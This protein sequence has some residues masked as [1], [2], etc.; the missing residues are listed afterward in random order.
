MTQEFYIDQVSSSDE[1]KFF[2]VDR[3]K[4]EPYSSL[5]LRED[6]STCPGFIGKGAGLSVMC[7]YCFISRIHFLSDTTDNTARLLYVYAVSVPLSRLPEGEEIEQWYPLVPKE[8]YLSLRTALRIALCFTPSDKARLR[9]DSMAQLQRRVPGQTSQFLSSS[10]TSEISLLSPVGAPS[11]MRIQ[12]PPSPIQSPVSISLKTGVIDYVIIVGPTGDASDTSDTRLECQENSLLFRYPA[13]D[14]PQ[15]PLPTKIEWFCFPGGPEVIIQASRPPSKLFSFVLVGGDDG[16]SRTY[17]VCLTVYHRPKVCSSS[18]RREGDTWHAT[19]VA[20]LTRVPLVDELKECLLAVAHAWLASKTTMMT[21]T[22]DSEGQLQATKSSLAEE[23][24][25][26]LCHRVL[27]PIRGVFGVQ[28]SITSMPISLVLPTNVSIYN[29]GG[30]QNRLSLQ[31][32][33]RSSLVGKFSPTKSPSTNFINIQQGFQPLV[34]SLAPIFQLFDIKTVIHLVALIL[35]EFRVLIHSSQFSLLC[36]FA[37]G[38]CALIYPFRWQHPYVPILPRVLSEYLQAPLPYILGVHTSWLPELLENGRPEHLV[39]VDI[40]RGAIQLQESQGPMLPSRLTKGLYQRIKRIIH[41]DVFDQG[42]TKLVDGLVGST[43]YQHQQNDSAP[44]CST[45]HWNATI[46]KQVRVEFVCYLSAMLMGYR[47]CL[48]F[49]NQKLPVFNKRRYF[50]TCASDNEVV[51]FVTRLFCTQ[52]F[53]GFLENHSSSELSV[54]HSVYLTFSRSKDLEWPQSM[55]PMSISSHA[56]A[57]TKANGSLGR[58]SG[59]E[60]SSIVTPVFTMPQVT[61]V[62]ESE[63]E[64]VERNASETAAPNSQDAME[65]DDSA[66]AMGESEPSA[67]PS[68]GVHIEELLDV[69]SGELTDPF[70][71]SLAAL[72]AECAKSATRSCDYKQ[73]AQGMGVDPRILEENAELFRDPHQV[74]QNQG[75]HHM[76]ASGHSGAFGGPNTRSLSN[77]EERTEQVLHKCLTS[78]FASDDM[79]T[80][81]DVRVSECC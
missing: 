18:K 35:C 72:E 46:E 53:Q 78:V 79:I 20:F 36:P 49:V 17:A 45:I 14:R 51:P 75:L 37:E 39:I 21:M 43:Q 57:T 69:L 80:P 60:S 1:F 74:N 41:P 42:G 48:F 77:E 58:T 65:H 62:L 32:T 27:I 63:G 6:V 55:P 68:L 64:D 3:T 44:H 61:E 16:M 76:G 22:R 30:G 23:L 71:M 7:R 38:L 9:V 33:K 8:T 4:N 28:F 73:V 52:A 50:S 81:E 59:R 19:C 29:S 5:P 34:Y 31:Q 56:T 10:A 12:I 70:M 25:V 15:F 13:I 47:D 2:C 24:L 40:D 66:V 11:K 26:D 67:S 54:F